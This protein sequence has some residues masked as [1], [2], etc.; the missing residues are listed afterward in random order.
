M[1]AHSF[2][3]GSQM[4]L[5]ADAGQVGMR[6]CS[7]VAARL[8]HLLLG[9]VARATTCDDAEAQHHADLD[10]ADGTWFYTKIQ[11]AL[12]LWHCQVSSPQAGTYLA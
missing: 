6:Q 9:N 10:F 5:P 12:P 4:V 8:A 1:S 7:W 11:Q 2:W 3:L